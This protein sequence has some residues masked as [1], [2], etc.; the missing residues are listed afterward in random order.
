MRTTEVQPAASLEDAV[1]RIGNDLLDRVD[2]AGPPSL[3]SRKG[4]QAALMEW[5]MRDEQFKVQLFRFVDVLPTLNSSAEVARH[6]REY[7]DPERVTLP[8]ALRAALAAS[9]LAGGLLG[10]GIKSQVEGMARQFMLGNEPK[11]ITATLRGLRDEGIAFTVDILGE[12]VVSER[13][14]DDYA[15]RYLDLMELLARETAKWPANKQNL[16]ASELTRS[17]QNDSLAPSRGEGR[18]EGF[19]SRSA[20][21]A[22]TSPQPSPLLSGAEREQSVRDGMSSAAL[23]DIS[24]NVSI[25]ISALYSQIHPADPD[26]AIEKLSARLRPL[27]RRAKELGA[28]INFDMES[29]ALKNLTLRLFKSVFSEEEF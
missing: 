16:A 18:G 17:V 2:Q 14:A 24:L 19:G 11:E 6:L 26:T 1:L 22:L 27:L 23:L 28:F 9:G 20:S 12:A 29:Y 25:K 5:A 8:P 10:G 13:E 4:L 7:L 21:A 3:F 15:Q